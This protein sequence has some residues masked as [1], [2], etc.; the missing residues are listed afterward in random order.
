MNKTDHRAETTGQINHFCN[1]FDQVVRCT[2]NGGS[3]L[4]VLLVA[5]KELGG[6]V[7]SVW[8]KR[9]TLEDLFLRE[10]RAARSG[11][12]PGGVSGSCE[13]LVSRGFSRERAEART[14]ETEWI[15]ENSIP[16]Q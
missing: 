10:L 1:G 12:P 9:Q 2:D 6:E 7:L 16:T 5:L 13:R 8:P 15:Q 14:R 11:S 4:G 3:L